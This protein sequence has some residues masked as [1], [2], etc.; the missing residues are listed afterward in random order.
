MRPV[1][2]HS[3][4]LCGLKGKAGGGKLRET[5]PP[6][7]R[8]VL[9][10]VRVVNP[11]GGFCCALRLRDAEEPAELLAQGDAEGRLR[12]TAVDVLQFRPAFE[13]RRY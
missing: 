7:S 1:L 13:I 11:T 3:D 6:A 5:K 4:V 9:A 12:P 8:I 2:G 10:G